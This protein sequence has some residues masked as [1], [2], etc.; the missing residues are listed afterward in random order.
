[1]KKETGL[2]MGCMTEKITDAADCPVCG[3]NDGNVAPASYLAPKTFLNG[4]Y[5]L[6]KLLSY[7]GEGA[8]YLAYDTERGM[9][10]TVKEYMPD[11]LC[12]REKG[13][14]HITV[15]PEC[16]PLYKTYLSEFAELN[17]SLIKADESLR[18]QRV[19]DVFFDNNT[20]Y[21]V[22]E[23]ISG[24][25]LKTYLSNLGG[26]LTWEQA[27]ELF[28][29]L[30]TTLNI[31]H[32]N[33]II[34]RGI[35]PSTII[36]NE[37]SELYLISFG[38]TA[39][40]TYGSELNFEVF[41]GYAPPELYNGC[42]RQGSWTDVYGISAVLYK[43]LT[44]ITP[45]DATE[46]IESETLSEP[47]MINRNIPK[48]VSS[49]I[50]DGLE[51]MREDRLETMNIFIDRLFETPALLDQTGE[52]YIRKP[53]KNRVTEDLPR[54]APVYKPV[55]RAKKKKSYAAA[56][57][58][59]VVL[60]LTFIGFLTAIILPI[61]NPGMFSGDSAEETETDEEKENISVA[62][63]TAAPV[64]HADTTSIII[65]PLYKVPNFTSPARRFEIIEKSTNYSFLQITPE[66]EFNGEIEAGY[67]FEQ[68]I[69][70]ET[71]VKNGTV[72]T[73]K[74]SKG[75]EFAVLP[76]YTG[77]T[78]DEYKG[79][80]SALN[81]KYKS[82]AEKNMDIEENKVIRCDVEIG[83]KVNIAEG[84]TVVVYYSTGKPAEGEGA[85]LG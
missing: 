79:M 4:R 69:A 33:G 17:K 62:A 70:P 39:S 10:I 42:D 74:V 8:L 58:L 48:N 57:T 55:S 2:C 18:M 21:S 14:E 47:M 52:T 20:V 83:G 60:C 6:G 59:C 13:Q 29:P 72:L 36:V 85:R 16:V 77:K 46:R 49:V 11:T 25:S 7:N 22:F 34:H 1:M 12:K 19:L 40:R 64:I 78:L 67:I 53:V 68:D 75:A 84:Q 50:A 23:Y 82:E 37:R 3:Y 81:I 35:S 27:K 45:P 44:G 28:P 26:I 73:V 24:I 15:K 43:V 38:I 54:H 61:V 66:Y 41:S 63:V 30:L 56:I 71:E 80:L 31:I 51:L 32:S 65:E 76:D 5:I 9:K